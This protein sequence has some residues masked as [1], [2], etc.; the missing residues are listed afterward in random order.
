MRKRIVVAVAVVLAGIVG[1]TLLSVNV[2]VR[3]N[4]DFIVGRAEQAL[5]RRL[6][7]D[8]IEVTFWPVGARLANVV[9]ADN[10]AFSNEDFLRAKTLW[11]ELHLLPL[12]LGKLHPKMMALDAPTI[13]VVRDA[14]GRYN[15]PRRASEKNAREDAGKKSPVERQDS[16]LPVLPAFNISSGTLRFRDLTDGSEL[17]ATQID[18]KT[19]AFESGEPFEIQLDAAIM[20][21]QPNLHLTSWIG[22]IGENHDFRDVPLAGEINATDLD[23]GQVNKALPQF[24]KA[25]PKALRFDGIYTIKELKFKG[26]LNDLSLKGA[27][28]GTDASFRFE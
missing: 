9:L 15:F 22:S 1:L 19:S 26:T 11:V 21:A 8:R 20:A 23:L 25:L 12:F 7:V 2:W 17:T 13:T 27:V 18:L 16:R 4:K 28:T 5:G 6:S 24:R 3:R 10:P 14:Q